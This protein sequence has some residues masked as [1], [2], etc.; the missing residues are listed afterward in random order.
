MPLTRVAH[1]NLLRNGGHVCAVSAEDMPDA[2]A[3]RAGERVAGEV[4]QVPLVGAQG[5]EGAARMQ[6]GSSMR[7]AVLLPAPTMASRP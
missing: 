4:V 1:Q 2:Q 6:Q 3:S 7:A 5:P